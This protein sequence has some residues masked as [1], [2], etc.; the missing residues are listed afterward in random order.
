MLVQVERVSGNDFT[1]QASYNSLLQTKTLQYPSGRQLDYT[2]D[3]LFRTTAI[4]DHNSQVNYLS[5]VSYGSA[6][7]ISSLNMGDGTT[8]TFG[9]DLNRMQLTSQQVTKSGNTLLNLSYSFSATAGQHGAGTSAGNTGQLIAMTDSTPNTTGTS[10]NYTYDLM[11]RLKTAQAA[12]GWSVSETYDRYGNR[13]QQS[14]VGVVNSPP[15]LNRLCWSASAPARV[16]GFIPSKMKNQY[17]CS[18]VRIAKKPPKP[19]AVNM[20]LGIAQAS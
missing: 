2:Y 11:G 18:S 13:W 9:Y 1:T 12:A 5:N 7:Q 16:G 10:V 8:E 4:T 15:S 3:A 17:K 14:P 6:G 19:G 20:N